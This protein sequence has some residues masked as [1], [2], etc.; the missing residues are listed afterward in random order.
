M[1]NAPFQPEYMPIL[2]LAVKQ[3]NSGLSSVIHSL[4]LNGS[5]MRGEA[6][7]GQSDVNMTLLLK[8]PLNAQ[9]ESVLKSIQLRIESRFSYLKRLSFNHTT[10]NQVSD[11]KNIFYWGFWFKHC[12]LCLSG[13]NI[14]EEFGSF[15][16]S[17]EVAKAFNGDVEE[18]ITEYK[19]KIQAATI[20][21]PYLEACHEIA[22]KL[23]FSS[24]SLVAHRDKCWA[25]TIE[26]CLEH[27][28][29]RYPDKYV[30]TERL[31]ILYHRKKV[32]KRAALGLLN[33][34][35]D[36]LVNE[37]KRIDRKIG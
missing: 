25:F 1:T 24:F 2:T 26:E 13:S 27:F 7:P 14:G 9:E 29:F 30:E 37:F 32:P 12:S 34:Y 33:M 21:G 6:K 17:W 4:Y 19:A 10:L 8:R 3:I 22:K 20:T 16:P 23:I 36:W 11:I 35:G 28:L 15:E 18:W 31:L 5:V